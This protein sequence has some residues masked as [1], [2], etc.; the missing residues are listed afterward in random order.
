M[1]NLTVETFLN[2]MN[3]L[4]AAR[5]QAVNTLEGIDREIMQLMNGNTAQ[6]KTPTAKRKRRERLSNG[7]G[8]EA[9]M[10]AFTQQPVMTFQGL[11]QA[12]P[13]IGNSTLYHLI[14]ELKSYGKL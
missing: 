9:V 10:A 2:R 8:R 4:Q 6:T 1:K 3:K 14:G 5:T 13:H 7:E 12:V 11:K